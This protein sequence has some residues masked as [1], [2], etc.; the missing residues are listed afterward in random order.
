M[1][2]FTVGE[3]ARRTAVTVRT[4]HHYEKLG[5]LVP[6]ARTASGHRRYEPGDVIRLH[7]IV[8]LKSLGVP[9]R[10]IAELLNAEPGGLLE[11][12]R[13]QRAALLERRAELDT[14]IARIDALENRVRDGGEPTRDDFEALM[15]TISMEHQMNWGRRYLTEV[16]G[17][18][19]DEADAQMRSTPPEHL[20]GTRRWAVLI[21]DVEAAIAA[22]EDPRGARAA[23]LAQRWRDLVF[24]FTRGDAEKL[25]EINRLYAELPANFAKP[26]SDEVERFIHAAAPGGCA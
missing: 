3:L 15:E 6:S 20:E 13:A 11:A 2:T 26:Y 10:E 18:T 8:T 17:M 9:L 19:A 1:H 23:E 12:L 25:A 14:A 4:L 21:A 7:R 16:R 24:A 22:G 5:L